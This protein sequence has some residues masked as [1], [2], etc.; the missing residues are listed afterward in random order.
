[1][2]GAK[3]IRGGGSKKIIS[4]Y[5]PPPL[6]LYDNHLGWYWKHKSDLVISMIYIWWIW[7]IIPKSFSLGWGW[8]YNNVKSKRWSKWLENNSDK[9]IF[10]FEKR[11]MLSF[12]FDHIYFI[13]FQYLKDHIILLHCHSVEMSFINHYLSI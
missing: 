5:V 13:T 10:G 2:G 11:E 8:I 4:E 6:F 9:N 3:I 1:M 12:N 7:L